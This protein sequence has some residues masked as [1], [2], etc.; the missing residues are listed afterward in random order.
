[1]SPRASN[2]APTTGAVVAAQLRA[3][4]V[5]MR[6]ELIVLGVLA[7]ATVGLV[8]WGYAQVDPADFDGSDPETVPIFYPVAPIIFLI[9]ALWPFSVWR[10][11]APSQRGYFWSLPIGQPMHTLLRVAAG[12]LMLM[13]VC[14]ACMLLALTLVTPGLLMYDGVELSFAAGWTPFVAATLIYFVLSPFAVAFDHP[15]RVIVLI[16]AAFGIAGIAVDG[17]D[18]DRLGDVLI[19]VVESFWI[20]FAGPTF[21]PLDALDADGPVVGHYLLWLGIGLTAT[22]AGAYWHRDAS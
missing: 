6:R 17:F 9:A 19:P 18:L 14:V 8:V 12:W 7:L 11:D 15:I 16:A 4:S 10:L 20:A 22:A 3:L 21:I 5:L 13:G 2:V 1:M